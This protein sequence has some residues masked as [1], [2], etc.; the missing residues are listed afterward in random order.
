VRRRLTK[1]AVLAAALMLAACGSSTA[2]TTAGPRTTTRQR[3][4]TVGAAAAVR[5]TNALAIDLLRK[6][7]GPNDNSVFSPYSI[8]AALAMVDAGARGETAAQIGR[9]LHAGGASGGLDTSNS[10]LT[11][12]L[13]RATSS[14]QNVP[15]KDAATLNLAGG[16]WV[17]SRL[18]LEQ[19]FSRTLS[20]DFAAR[21]QTVDFQGNPEGVRR[22][23]NSYV[24]NRTANRIK[25]LMPPGSITSQT[26]LVLA[27]AVYLKAHWSEPFTVSDT[28]PAM[29]TTASG[30][31][32]AAPFMT[33]PATDFA[34]VRRP[35]YQA[36]ELPYLHSTLSMV[37]VMP[38]AGTLPRFEQRLTAG[39][40]SALEGALRPER[41][42]LHMPRFHLALAASLDQPLAA[43][44]MPIAFTDHADF[45]GIASAPP[46]KISAV[47]HGADLRVDEN[48]TI[49]AAATGI[50]IGPT[51]VAPSPA[52]TVTLD[53]PF[54]LFL[55][56]T[57]SGA[58]LFAGRVADPSGP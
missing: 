35:G 55:G 21:P 30:R 8:Q 14:P 34:Y 12:Q 41:I 18:S 27:N 57:R 2:T 16:M 5:S 19:S 31:H 52:I 42:K 37:I 54:L 46:L 22:S 24:A 39:S 45:S 28:A 25:Q 13:S 36:I 4:Q 47:Q 9:V 48:G 7:G 1:P 56:D 40:L 3:A 49:A 11:D 53:H 43:L 38:S 58:I 17:T 50:A 10:A 26:G 29:F 33:Q 15:A 51:A 44:G 20:S 23:I 6:L 32:V